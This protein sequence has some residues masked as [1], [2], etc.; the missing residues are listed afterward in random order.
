M[1]IVI[2]LDGTICKLR[3]PDQDYADVEPIA[4]AIHTICQLKEEGHEIIIYTAR[5]MRTQ[6]GNVGRV[7]A[8]VGDITLSWLDRHGIPY[9]E[10]VFGKPYGHVYIDDLAHPFRDWS[11]VRDA[12]AKREADDRERGETT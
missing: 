4:G 9:D 8:H 7:L 11:S 5:N 3:R 2:D 1:R 10:I 6:Q 12:L